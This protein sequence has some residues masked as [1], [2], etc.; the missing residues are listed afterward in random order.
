MSQKLEWLI[1]LN[2]YNFPCYRCYNRSRVKI[3]GNPSQV[4]CTYRSD[5]Q[6]QLCP[7]SETLGVMSSTSYHHSDVTDN[8]WC[9]YSWSRS[10]DSSTLADIQIQENSL[11]SVTH[12]PL[13]EI[14]M[15]GSFPSSGCQLGES[16]TKLKNMALSSDC[17][18]IFFAYF[19]NYSFLEVQILFLPYMTELTGL[20]YRSWL[21][22]WV[23]WLV[24][25]SLVST[26]ERIFLSSSLFSAAPIWHQMFSC[27]LQV[28]MMNR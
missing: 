25:M 17:S 14:F 5:L 4:I 20:A 22:L 23:P 6:V 3:I 8:L 12:S 16:E 26:E 21:V 9:W 11:S 15:M 28:G 18:K 1:Q 2:N 7:N 13:L 27:L 19:E 24:Q 10:L